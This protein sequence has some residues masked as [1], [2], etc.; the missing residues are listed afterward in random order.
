MA[1]FLNA[2]LKQARILSS[3]LESRN[4]TV[5]NGMSY[6]DFHWLRIGI[7]VIISWLGLKGLLSPYRHLFFPNSSLGYHDLQYTDSS[8][9]SLLI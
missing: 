5:W 1:K 2:S 3:G 9:I 8:S 4:G 6:R 7:I